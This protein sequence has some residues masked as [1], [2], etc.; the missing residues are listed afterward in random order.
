MD[1]ARVRLALIQGDSERVNRW[2][3]QASS[4]SRYMNIFEKLTLIRVY[5]ADGEFDKASLL[6]EQNLKNSVDTEEQK[7]RA[8]EIFFLKA[9]VLYHQQF[10]DSALISLGYAL[11]LAEPEGYIRLFASEG[12]PMAALLEELLLRRQKGML[13]LALSR[14][15]YVQ[16]LLL[17]CGQHPNNVKQL[18]S[19]S[20][21]PKNSESL[22]ALLSEK[23]QSILQLLIAGLSN[24]EISKKL[25]ISE[26]TVKWYV[27]SIYSKIGAH[28][29]V[30]AVAWAS[31]LQL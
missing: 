21:F 27:K 16:N 29:R 2:K 28:N 22:P 11:D 7:A 3:N 20:A 12:Q 17:A 13:T 31:K 26:N 1:T 25:I 19:S 10:L 15:N 23:E 18:M 9:L 24:R 5:I 4:A 30:Q 8:I 14:L 6:I